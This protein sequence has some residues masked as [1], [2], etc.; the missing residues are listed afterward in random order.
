MGKEQFLGSWRLISSVFKSVSSGQV[1]YPLG[2]DAT[3]LIIYSADGYM[4]AQLLS[5]NR[6]RFASGDHLKGTQEEIKGA[7]EGLMTYYGTYEVDEKQHTVSHHCE[8]SS[9]PNWDGQVLNRYYEFSDDKMTLSTPQLKMGGEKVVGVLIWQ[10][11][12][13]K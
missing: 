4:S 9:F 7:F 13:V 5:P 11:V 10:R 12:K 8:R 6:P 2:K 1:A 3:G